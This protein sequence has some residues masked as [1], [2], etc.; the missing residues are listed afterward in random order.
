M[1]NNSN[2][3]KTDWQKAFE[4]MLNKK[5]T[6]AEI[7]AQKMAAKDREIMIALRL[8]TKETA[9]KTLQKLNQNI[10]R[11]QAEN[12]LESPKFQNIASFRQ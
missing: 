1:D 2:S 10:L 8:Y 3:G 9:R 7:K 6:K 4:N 11:N 5:P 12:F